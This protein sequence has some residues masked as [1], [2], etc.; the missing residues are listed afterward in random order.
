MAGGGEDAG[1]GDRA[2]SVGLAAPQ[3]LA[4]A[5]PPNG[6]GKLKVFISYSR[7]DSLDFADQ[8]AAAL[9]A[10]GYEAVVDRHG[11]AGGEDWQ[12]RL[13]ALIL[14]AD[15]VV[16]VL[17]PE[18]VG[19]DVCAWEVAETDRRAKRLL[20]VVARPLGSASVPQRL[21]DLNYIFF[22]AEPSAPGSGFGAGLAGLV[23]A[24]NTDLDWLREHTRLGE[25]AAGWEA[26]GR[27]ENRLLTG[28]DID[29][30]KAWLARQ[31]KTAPEP[32][33]VLRAFV[34]ASED[35][36]AA[37]A[38]E[39][40]RRLDEM[41]AAQEERAKALTAAEKALKEAAEAQRGHARAR[42]IIAWGSA[43]AA[44]VMAV[45]LV[46]ANSKTNEALVAQQKEN[47]A[48]LIALTEKENAQRQEQ[49]ARSEKGRAEQQERA[50]V[51]AKKKAEENLR[52]AEVIQSR[53]LVFRAKQFADRGDHGTAALLALE[54][55]PDANA[56]PETEERTVHR[57]FVFEAMALLT[58]ELGKLREKRLFRNAKAI[59]PDGKLVLISGDGAPSLA[60]A[61][62][63][64]PRSALQGGGAIE[65]AV[66]SPNGTL[67]LTL[68]GDRARL[69][70]TASGASLGELGG[71]GFAAGSAAFSP[72]GT[73]IFT[74]ANDSAP[75]LWNVATRALAFELGGPG[76]SVEDYKFSPDGALLLTESRIP[77]SSRERTWRL[78]DTAT[79]RP[80]FTLKQ[81]EN[82][83]KSAFF[84]LDKKLALITFEDKTARLRETA[85]GVERL[86]L[87]DA[88]PGI[89]AAVFS[90]D[91]K[92]LLTLSSSGTTQLWDAATGAPRRTLSDKIQVGDAVFRPDGAV[93]LTKPNG[94]PWQA[95]EVA[96]GAS[97]FELG[98]N[99]KSADKAIFSP[100]GNLMATLSWDR[101]DVW[102]AA[103][104]KLKVALG[105]MES[106]DG[107]AFA[108]D[109]GILSINSSAQIALAWDARPRS[110]LN[111]SELSAQDLVDRAKDALPRCLAIDQRK[112]HLLHPAPP[113]WCMKLGKFPYD[114][115]AWKDWPKVSNDGVL[116][117]EFNDFADKA[118]KLAGDFDMA[119]EAADICLKFNPDT[120]M[121]HI[122][123]GHALMYL[124]RTDEA[125]EEYM[126]VHGKE[127]EGH[128]PFDQVV[129]D[130]F[131]DLERN[132]RERPPLMD[133]IEKIFK[134]PA[135]PSAQP[136]QP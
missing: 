89:N 14:A 40:R 101:A 4:G 45:L 44:V 50:A 67:L 46:F 118:L 92:A 78:W 85:A 30:A 83:A 97:V 128:G 15:T 60:D 70:D 38:S 116:A 87:M 93:V 20:P 82:G 39:A 26:R 57:P 27:P 133:E 71:A 51:E 11:I 94:K 134:A 69:W 56:D 72:D 16:F 119:L 127:W 105:G 49:I 48:K 32:T 125:R 131:K 104:G 64:A 47:Q 21:R 10:Y 111:I 77:S 107:V 25:L 55:L 110:G 122:N 120:P 42:T 37:R 117:N 6:A 68:E 28:T 102:S 90:P 41:A 35:G 23:A 113:L 3:P 19:S 2:K 66:F 132:G 123:R 7:R 13:G 80:S 73:F 61:G 59:S 5:A 52:K 114:G 22:Y 33:A 79:G 76:Q 96:T 86:T 12:K 54:A 112:E 95:W 34:T 100:D 121:F 129:V 24:L 99:S 108:A 91:G 53:E 65:S 18:S 17:S 8:L 58:S 88:A 43:G 115:K 9:E 1:L 36:A 84:S 136:A 103:N 135:T 31:P 106:V 126:S 29:D 63:G 109:G 62:T 98:D 124:G 130:D 74:T 75:R 81:G